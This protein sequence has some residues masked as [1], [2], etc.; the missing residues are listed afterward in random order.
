M[1]VHRPTFLVTFFLLASASLLG[2]T[3]LERADALFANGFFAEAEAAYTDA[4]QKSPHDLKVSTLLGMTALFSNH[5]DDAEKYLREAAQTGP[6][7]TV[8]Q[9]LLGE[10]FYRRDQ[11]PEAARWFRAAGSAERAG[12]LESFREVAPYTIEGPR[13][14]TRLPFVATD[15]L[16]IV[17]VRVNGGDAA[18]FL[19]DTGGA[20][21]QLDSEFAQRIKLASAG[22]GSVTLLD[23]NQTE[24]RHGRVAALQLGE[25]EVRDVPVEIRRLPV[26]AGRKL[27]GVLGTVLLYHFLATLDYPNGELVLRRRSVEVLRAF[28]TRAQLEKQIVMPFW[29]ASDHMMVTRGRVNHAPPALLLVATGFTLGFTCPESMIE[30]ASLTFN[31][32]GSIVPATERR[33]NVAAFVVNELYLGEARQQNVAGLAGAFPAGWEHAYG[34][35]IAGLV[36]HQFFRPYAVTFDFN[37]MRLLLGGASP[38]PLNKTPIDVQTAMFPH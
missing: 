22:G 23:G 33:A 35:R 9:N 1:R 2:A 34:F 36:G 12:P 20:E 37:G 28:E 21:V 31:R 16:P 5:L 15:P 32:N 6:F 38:R 8:A 27:D 26:F 29:L 7:Q 3:A 24:V 30:Q 14:E 10:V 11:F 19:I 13:D 18:T 25:F 17:Q 4:L